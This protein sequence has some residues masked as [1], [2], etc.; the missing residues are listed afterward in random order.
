M[1]QF[2]LKIFLSVKIFDKSV[3]KGAAKFFLWRDNFRKKCLSSVK[4]SA[5]HMILQDMLCLAGIFFMLEMF[6]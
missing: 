4:I 3:V 5:K 1:Y 2:T 6:I